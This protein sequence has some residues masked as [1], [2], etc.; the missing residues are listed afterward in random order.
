MDAWIPRVIF[1]L[2]FGL[3]VWWLHRGIGKYPT[4]LPRS[5]DRKGE[6]WEIAILYG[7]AISISTLDT[8][9]FTPWLQKTV[10]NPTLQE[11]VRL[12]VLTLFYAI[13]PLLLVV[14]RNGWAWKDLGFTLHTQS[15][16]VSFFAVTVGAV[17]GLVAFLTGKSNMGFEAIAPGAL[18]LLIYNNAIL[19]EFFYR[20]VLQAKLERG[21]GQMGAIVWGGILFGLKHLALDITTLFDSGGILAVF[22]AL[23]LQTLSGWL[24]GIIYMKTRSLWPG[25]VSHYLGNWLPSILL[26]VFN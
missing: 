9:C 24:L 3:L 21:V 10:P 14:K 12:P 15:K 8:L 26:W 1:N 17:T 20:G 7:M 18:I 19:E 4:P 11:L 16:E 13:L 25:I 6:L 22:L 2:I 5:A 23:M